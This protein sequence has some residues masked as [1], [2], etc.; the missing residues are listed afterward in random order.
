[1]NVRAYFRLMRSIGYDCLESFVETVFAV[2]WR[3]VTIL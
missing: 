1:M 2:L 3:K